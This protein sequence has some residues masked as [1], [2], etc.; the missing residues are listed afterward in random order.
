MLI[1]ASLFALALHETHIHQPDDVAALEE[2]IMTV[3][4]RPY[5]RGRGRMGGVRRH[6]TTQIESDLELIE[7]DQAPITEADVR[8][9]IIG[10]E[11][12]ITSN[13][14]ADHHTGRF[15][16]AG[17]PNAIREQ[18]HSWR[19]PVE[20]ELAAQPTW[21]R[22]GPMGVGV[23][24]VLFDPTAAEWYQGQ[25]GS[26][27]QYE[28]LSGATALGLD[29]HHGHVQPNGT[30]H[31]HGIPEGLLAGLDFEEDAHSPIIG[32]ALDGFP[33]YALF[34]ANA[35]GEIVEMQSSWRLRD[36][37]RATGDAQ[38]GGTYDGTFTADYEYVAG[39]GD[40]NECNAAFVVNSDYPDGTWAYFLTESFPVVPRCFIGADVPQPRRPMAMRLR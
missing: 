33:I 32:W 39:L 20:P 6:T 40:L 14:I 17:N 5:P 12:V 21:R 22:L 38:P 28:A 34:G 30:Y 19:M 26:I 24:G 37:A 1:S 27:W 10:D 16:H 25:R 15:P 35:A 4:Q 7:A 9:E 36:G 13:N 11:R 8:I 31:Y 2:D 3:E 23:N 29:E 18:S